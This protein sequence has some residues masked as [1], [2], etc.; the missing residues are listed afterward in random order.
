MLWYEARKD[1]GY[2]ALYAAPEARIG[3][4]APS[5]RGGADRR[6]AAASR[7][8][9]A[10]AEGCRP[11]RQG[12]AEECRTLLERRRS[13]GGGLF[14]R[15][16]MRLCLLLLPALLAAACSEAEPDFRGGIVKESFDYYA[17]RINRYI[18]AGRQDSVVIDM[19]PHF[20]RAISRRDT[21]VCQLLGASIAQAWLELENRDSVSRYIEMLQPYMAGVDDGSA[22]IIYHN[23]LGSFALKY[24]A[25]YTGALSHYLKVLDNAKRREIIPAQI[26]MLYNIVYIFYI[27]KDPHCSQYAE[28]ALSL[29]QTP[30]MRFFS[31]ITAL[32]AKVKS[33]YLNKSYA[34]AGDY[35]RQAHEATLKYNADY[36]IPIIYMLQGDILTAEKQY[37][38]AIR[39]YEMALGESANSEPSTIISILYN[40]GCLC[41]ASGRLQKADELYRQALDKCAETGSTE[42]LVQLLRAMVELHIQTGDI[43]TVA[44]YYNELIDKEDKF[45]FQTG[46]GDFKNSLFEYSSLQYEYDITRK[47]LELSENRRTTGLLVFFVSVAALCAAFALLLYARQRRENK[48]L[49]AQYEEYRKHLLTENSVNDRTAADHRSDIHYALYLKMEQLM[50]AG[51]FREKELTLDRMAEVLGTNRTYVSNALNKVAGISFFGYIDSYRIKEAT[52]ILSDSALSEGISLKQLADDVGYNNIQTFFKAFKRETGVTPGNYKKEVLNLRKF[53][54]GEQ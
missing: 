39:S 10:A 36:W 53:T 45:D 33:E 7:V 19:T 8:A 3:R 24:H 54:Q 43:D 25:D 51:L 49:I 4:E 12:G 30:N 37:D 16:W 21:A 11:G 5:V 1:M 14:A 13:G 26:T 22:F 23:M 35:L 32:V 31:L 34:E 47:S 18:Y 42:F 29:A 2:N 15:A 40:Y 41:Q 38:K 9:G 50:K 6:V 17:E 20:Y 44:Y 46:V 27:R 28:M 48:R 52:R